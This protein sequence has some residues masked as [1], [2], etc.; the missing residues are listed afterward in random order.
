VTDET[1]QFIRTESNEFGLSSIDPN[2]INIFPDYSFR[3]ASRWTAGLSYVFEKRGLLSIDYS[4]QDFSN[5][6]FR[7]NAIQFL[8]TGIEQNLT[9]A[10]N[11]NVGGEYV[12]KQLRFR[13]G[14]FMQESPYEDD[15]VRGDL[16][17]YSFGL[18]YNLNNINIDLAYTLASVDRQDVL[19]QTGL[20]Q[21]ASVN[22][23]IS[24]IFLTVSF[25]F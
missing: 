16:S 3:T 13:G 20:S 24:N 18:G 7:S 12:Y 2:V 6:K 4:I 25:G 1:E 10:A 14:Y 8:N 22:Q 9:S 21:M 15:A 23:D 5:S 11:L 17:G 19:Y